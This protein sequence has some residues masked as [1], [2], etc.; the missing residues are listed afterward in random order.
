VT[1]KDVVDAIPV[2]V[3]GIEKV[4]NTFKRLDGGPSQKKW[5]EAAHLNWEGSISEVKIQVNFIKLFK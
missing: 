1:I 5:G 3:G 2:V 4:V